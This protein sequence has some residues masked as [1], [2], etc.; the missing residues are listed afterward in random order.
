[1]DA[2]PVPCPVVVAPALP[3]FGR[4]QRVVKCTPPSTGRHTPVIYAASSEA[5]N[6]AARATSQAV[7]T[8]PVVQRSLRSATMAYLSASFP[9]MSLSFNGASMY[10]GIIALSLI[11]AAAYSTPRPA[12][13]WFM[14]PFAEH[15][16]DA[17]NRKHRQ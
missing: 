15:S 12:L 13:N 17:E 10:P 16:Q 5:R 8:C 4:R 7:L 1:M 11:P 9:A 2:A 3:G 6:T 14:P